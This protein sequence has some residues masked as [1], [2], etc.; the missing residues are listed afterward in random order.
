VGA[1]NVTIKNLKLWCE[2]RA[3]KS[4]IHTTNQKSPLSSGEGGTKGG[5]G[6]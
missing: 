3:Y 6:S 4:A 5:W 1:M 2:F